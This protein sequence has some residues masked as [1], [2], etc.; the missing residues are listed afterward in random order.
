MVF[1]TLADLILGGEAGGNKTRG[2]AMG[3]GVKPLYCMNDTWDE[4]Y[5]TCY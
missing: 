3:E 2:G 5:Y 4:L 1:I